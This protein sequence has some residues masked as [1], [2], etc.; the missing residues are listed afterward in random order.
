MGMLFCSVTGLNGLFSLF[1]Q[2]ADLLFKHTENAVFNVYWT[3][4][5]PQVSQSRKNFY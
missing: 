2:N 3:G 4:L 5:T 1:F